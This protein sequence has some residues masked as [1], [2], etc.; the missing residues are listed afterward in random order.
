MASIGESMTTSNAGRRELLVLHALASYA[1]ACVLPS[2]TPS[3]P[4]Y[5]VD[6]G[7]PTC[8]EECRE[9]LR[10]KGDGGRAVTEVN[11]DGLIMTGRAI[12]RSAAS[13]A[14][15]FDAAEQYI[16]YSDEA[17]SMRSTSALLTGLQVASFRRFW[18]SVDDNRNEPTELWG[19][20]D[21]RGLDVERAAIGGLAQRMA[22]S[23]GVTLVLANLHRDGAFDLSRLPSPTP[24]VTAWQE[25]ADL[26]Y[27]RSADIADG[28]RARHTADLLP[29]NAFEEF[30]IDGL[31]ERI[32][33]DPAI[34]YP[35]TDGFLPR[36]ASWFAHLFSDNLQGALDGTPPPSGVFLGLPNRFVADEIGKWL[37]DRFTITR[38]G[39]WEMSSLALEWRSSAGEALDGCVARLLA[40]R[41]IE[42]DQVAEIFLDRASEGRGRDRPRTS[43][44]ANAFAQKASADLI[45]GR[46]EDAT[47]VFRGLVDLRP[48]DG[49]AWNNLG[50][51]Q[52]VQSPADALQSL[53]RAA[54]LMRPNSLICVANTMLALHLLKRDEEATTLADWALTTELALHRSAYMWRHPT[55]V[56]TL[57][58]EPEVAPSTYFAELHEHIVLGRCADRA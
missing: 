42:R 58:L 17:V 16:R 45:N 38:L 29:E 11:I 15:Q 13:G 51:C 6:D 36:A 48:G 41:I 18:P 22:A 40:E 34:H 39:E 2:L 49:E 20:L 30:G 50:F 8:G 53:Q 44:H 1:D 57:E 10:E 32:H 31:D 21:R 47:R 7:N 35:L 37:W 3:C 55:S 28:E 25:I 23:L 33:S 56:G 43:L 27:A 24:T 54:T 4:F 9:F 26:S 46:V 12:P 14:D 19:E 52:L 5:R